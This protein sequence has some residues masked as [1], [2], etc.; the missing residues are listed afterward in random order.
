MNEVMRPIPNYGS[1]MPMEEF[2]GYCK[3]GG[4][5]DYDGYG[6]YATETQC[7]DFTVTPSD[8]IRGSIRNGW[9]HVVWYNR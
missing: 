2:I 8:V 5:I 9:T 7:S 3:T 1:H 4:F 6:N